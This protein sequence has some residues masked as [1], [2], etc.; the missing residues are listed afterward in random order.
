M[1]ICFLDNVKTS[2]TSKDIYTNKIRGAENVVVNLSI[3][4]SKLNHDVIIYNNCE[5]N[6]KINNAE[7]VFIKRLSKR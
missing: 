4:L 2:Y 6:I 5:G 3:E 1:K 7:Y